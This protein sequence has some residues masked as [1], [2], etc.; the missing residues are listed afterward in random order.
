MKTNRR[1][2]SDET[3]RWTVPRYPGL[4]FTSRGWGV[5]PEATGEGEHQAKPAGPLLIL[6]GVE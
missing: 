6:A 3:S 4:Y 1:P 2:M 5:D